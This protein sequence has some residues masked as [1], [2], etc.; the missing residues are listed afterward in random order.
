[1][2]KYIINESKF[3]ELIELKRN[4]KLVE[5]ILNK[6]D[7]VNNSLNENIIINEA[8]H[9]IILMY[10]KKNLINE[11]VKSLLIQ[12]GKLTKRQLNTIKL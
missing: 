8:I 3:K 10:K 7:K 6:I 5:T 4:R 9:D 11:N 2:K 12:S 1:M